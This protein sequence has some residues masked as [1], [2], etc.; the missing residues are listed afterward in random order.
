MTTIE[1]LNAIFCQ[2]FDDDSIQ[3]ENETTANDIDGWDSLSHVNLIVAVETQFGIKFSQKE[4]VSFKNVGDLLK[5]IESK[6][7]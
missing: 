7:S 5:R 1:K 6:I 3:I 2:V 4:L